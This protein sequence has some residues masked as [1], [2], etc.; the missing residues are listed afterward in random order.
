MLARDDAQR[1]A[2]SLVREQAD[3][4]TRLGE[5][6]KRYLDSLYVAAED[7]L[8]HE[9]TTGVDGTTVH[10]V[11]ALD[12]AVETLTRSEERRV[13]N[14]CVSKYSRRRAP[15]HDKTKN[16]LRKRGDTETY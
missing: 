13:G 11:D 2:T 9:T 16:T 3:P 15:H 5:A 14:E 1:S 10:I 7:L 4:A 8:R 6:S 12:T